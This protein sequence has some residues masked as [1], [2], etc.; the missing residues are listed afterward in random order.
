MTT[1]GLPTADGNERFMMCPHYL[2]GADRAAD[3][4]WE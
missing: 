4:G 2:C 1:I 3:D